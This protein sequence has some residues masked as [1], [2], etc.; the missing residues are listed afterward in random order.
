M[1]RDLPVPPVR[2]VAAILQIHSANESIY[3]AQNKVG[4]A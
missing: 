3:E 2:I 1:Q 4:I